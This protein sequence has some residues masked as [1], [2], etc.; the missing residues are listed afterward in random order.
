MKTI[1]IV[2]DTTKAENDKAWLNDVVERYAKTHDVQ[3]RTIYTLSC[4]SRNFNRSLFFR[5]WVR[6][7]VVFTILKLARLLKRG[8]AV[9]FWSPYMACIWYF[10]TTNKWNCK[11]ISMGWLQPRY[12]RMNRLEKKVFNS[13]DIIIVTK[14]D[15]NKKQ[16]IDFFEVN[17]HEKVQ[18]FPDVLNLKEGIYEPITSR[19]PIVFMGGRSNRD[20]YSFLLYA[21]EIP[22]IR[23]IG[24]ASKKDWNLELELMQ[25]D[26]VEMYFDISLDE[27]N[28]YMMNSSFVLTLLKDLDKTSGLINIIR[29]SQWGKICIT[30]NIEA[31]RPYYPENLW[32]LL[33]EKDDGC[34][35]NKLKRLFSLSDRDYLKMAKMQQ[36]YVMKHYS[37]ETFV[38]LLKNN[39]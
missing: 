5:I 24:C 38:R 26:N 28:R 18:I 22:K 35:V 6:I 33:L 27:Y 21:R 11:V 12:S 16:L 8:D 36:E 9:I 39:L 34:N 4:L 7:D 37:P 20:W 15:M 1:Y 19:H 23:F 2:F 13:E 25:S 30:T 14:N 3:T 29:A 32:E 17:N 10:L 31:V